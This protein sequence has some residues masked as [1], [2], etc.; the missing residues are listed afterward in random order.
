MYEFLI[1]HDEERLNMLKSSTGIE[2]DIVVDSKRAIDE[3]V[4]FSTVQGIDVT[5]DFIPGKKSAPPPP[6]TNV[7]P[8]KIK[9]GRKPK[10]IVKK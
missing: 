6:V 9:F 10:L 3:F 1:E 4:I 8:E 2:L 5:K 7:T